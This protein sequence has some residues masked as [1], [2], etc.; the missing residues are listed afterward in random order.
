MVDFKENNIFICNAVLVKMFSFKLQEKYTNVTI[1]F[2]REDPHLHQFQCSA[3]TQIFLISFLLTV[4]QPD[5][6]SIYL[7][8]MAY[9]F[10]SKKLGAEV[11][12]HCNE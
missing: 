12:A 1:I 4:H 7:S 11:E 10:H 2:T 6:T 8:F 9:L 3:H 5:S